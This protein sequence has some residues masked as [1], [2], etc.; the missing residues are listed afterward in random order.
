MLCT[1]ATSLVKS[2]HVYCSE[3]WYPIFFGFLGTSG[4]CYFRV[5]AMKIGTTN[6]YNKS[7]NGIA[8][9]NHV[10]GVCR[11]FGNNVVTMLS[12]YDFAGNCQTLYT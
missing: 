1:V 3:L 5:S 8:V 6:G 12:F 9:K 10:N 4:L 11:T 2:A 7:C